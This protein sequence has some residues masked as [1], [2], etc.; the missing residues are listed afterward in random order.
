[1][2]EVFAQIQAPNF[3]M[4]TIEKK[5]DLWP[6]FKSVLTRD[7]RLYEQGGGPSNPPASEG[8]SSATP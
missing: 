8:A 3:H 5:E 2:L 7:R 4:I 1:M 6:A